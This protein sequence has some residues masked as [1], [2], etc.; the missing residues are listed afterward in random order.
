[1]TSLIVPKLLFGLAFAISSTLSGSSLDAFREDEF[2]L[3]YELQAINWTKIIN[4][5]L[6]FL[7]D[8]E[9]DIILNDALFES[10]NP[11]IIVSLLA[12]EHKSQGHANHQHAPEFSTIVESMV[13]SLVDAYMDYED[14][15]AT[16][17]TNVATSAIWEVLDRDD[18]KLK[19][20]LET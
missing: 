14:N 7:N 3:S 1:M 8:E 5:E 20:F 10:V 13:S 16:V 4:D 17:K 9:G 15:N 11:L 6:P 12:T 18:D 19:L 2:W